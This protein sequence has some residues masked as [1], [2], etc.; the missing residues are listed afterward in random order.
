MYV[1][2]KDR[3]LCLDFGEICFVNLIIDLIWVLLLF[4]FVSMLDE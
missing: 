1:W 3:F 2:L 4:W